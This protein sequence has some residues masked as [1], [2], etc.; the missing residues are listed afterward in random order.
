[1][2]VKNGCKD[3][4]RYSQIS[5]RVRDTLARLFFKKN[6]IPPCVPVWSLLKER[7]HTVTAASAITGSVITVLAIQQSS[8]KGRQQQRNAAV[9]DEPRTARCLLKA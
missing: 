5:R 2:H 3:L 7:H 8:S 4:K 1:M 6:T 9:S